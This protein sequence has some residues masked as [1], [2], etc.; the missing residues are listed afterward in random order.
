MAAR[1]VPHDEIHRCLTAVKAH[2]SVTEAAKALGISRT[3]LQARVGRKTDELVVPAPESG[4]VSVEDILAYKRK[5]FSQKKR[6]AVQGAVLKVPIRGDEP[7]AIWHFGDP[8]LD[9]DGCDIDTLERHI[10][11]V[12]STPRLWCA[13]VGDTTNNWVGRL[14]RLYAHQVT[15][16]SQAW[17]LAEWFIGKLR[18]RWSYIVGGNHDSWS[19]AS[20]PLIWISK[21]A[22]AVY[23]SSE[24]IAQL[25]WAKDRH[26]EV[27]C[28]HDFAGHSQWNPAHGPTKAL[29]L[30]LRSHIAIAGHKHSSGY[31]VIKSPDTGRT[32]HAVRVASYKYFDRYARDHGFRDQTLSPGCMT[33]VNT[34]LPDDHPDLVK[35][36]WDCAEGARYLRFLQ[37]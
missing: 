21:Q 14:A 36:F 26:I 15:T 4:E 7:W 17:K 28:R 5:V 24:V 10:E 6:A 31:G 34:H 29:L 23:Q 13:N 2:G 1:P 33:V 32:C 12:L 25:A 11:I 9:D 18:G 19:G 35:V 30:G 37:G 20:D 16:D 8:H 27:N 22:N 3:T